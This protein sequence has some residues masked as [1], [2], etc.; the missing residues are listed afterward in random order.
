M[1]PRHLYVHVPF[2]ARRCAYCDFS[3]AVRRITP[4]DEYLRALRM[5]LAML[6]REQGGQNTAAWP[7]D[8]VYLGGGTPSQLGSA[9]PRVLDAISEVATIAPGA[10]V[11]IE[12]NPE[13][14]TPETA[15][16]WRRAGANRISLGSQ[17]FDPVVLSWMHRVHSAEQIPRAVEIAR[18]AG[19]DNISLD[20]IFALPRSL[21]RDWKRDLE[22]A[23]ALDPE[24]VSLYGLTIEPRT[25]LS[26]WRD[27]GEVREA[28]DEAYAAEFLLAHDTLSAAGYDHYEV[29]N[30]ARPGLNSRHNSSYWSGAA[31]AGI[32]PSAHSFDGSRRWWNVAPY[33]E[34]IERLTAGASPVAEVE[35]LDEE[36]LSNEQVYLGL[37]TTDGVRV[38][39]DELVELQPWL[40]RGWAAFSQPVA[41]QQVSRAA[42]EWGAPQERLSRRRSSSGAPHPGAAGEQIAS[43][44]TEQRQLRLT[45]SGW[46]LLDELA[47][48]LTCIR[49]RSYV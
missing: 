32:G 33:A 44:T 47:T 26:H 5:E 29:S 20:L 14:V 27:R 11:T 6:A 16:A 38:A 36:N 31:Y 1:P 45:P 13:D 4:V 18:D 43:S 10:E 24:H 40:D 48:N 28:A 34:W 7:L 39:A 42:P 19:F 25:P 37:R 22:S 2:C 35:V 15:S 49:S 23:L 12:A 21:G 8:T 46:L 9:L 30:F 17:S 3:I 41:A